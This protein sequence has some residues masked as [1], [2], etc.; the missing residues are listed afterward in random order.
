MTRETTLGQLAVGDIVFAIDG[1]SRPFPY[2]V[3][4]VDRFGPSVSVR[5]AH[6]GIVPACDAK[7]PVTVARTAASWM[8]PVLRPPMRSWLVLFAFA[9][10]ITVLAASTGHGQQPTAPGRPSTTTTTTAR[11]E[12][13]PGWN[14]RTQGNRICGSI[15]ERGTTP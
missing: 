1:K 4:R 13:D 2:E 10:L 8:R 6:G 14:C 11:V 9:V 12:D 15:T 3:T 7:T 5:Y